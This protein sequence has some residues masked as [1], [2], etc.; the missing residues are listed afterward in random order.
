MGNLEF[1][2]KLF[3]KRTQ[4]QVSKWP[5]GLLLATELCSFENWAI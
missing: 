3:D 5:T 2:K 1:D 4:P